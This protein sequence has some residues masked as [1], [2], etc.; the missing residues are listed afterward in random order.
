MDEGES[1][2]DDG[3][4][5]TVVKLLAEQNDLL[6][7]GKRADGVFYD[8]FTSIKHKEHS[9]EA[10]SMEYA[11]ELFTSFKGTRVMPEL[12]RYNSAMQFSKLNRDL[13]EFSRN[14][15]L[16][17]EAIFNFVFTKK[18]WHQIEKEIATLSRW[19][20][21]E[22]LK[23]GFDQKLGVI[24]KTAKPIAVQR[25]WK[26][27]KNAFYALFLQSQSQ[28]VHLVKSIEVNHE[29]DDQY[30]NVYKCRYSLENMFDIWGS[31]KEKSQMISVG[32]YAQI[33]NIRRR[34]DGGLE[35]R[36]S[37]P[38]SDYISPKP[39][40]V[41]FHLKGSTQ[42]LDLFYM[43][44]TMRN[45]ASHGFIDFD[46]DQAAVYEKMTDGQFPQAAFM[47]A[48]ENEIY[49]MATAPGL[50]RFLSQIKQSTPTDSTL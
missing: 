41:P 3:A 12:I 45:Y 33:Q 46:E 49:R 18:H 39:Y 2:S 38:A 9:W 37:R 20:K 15:S 32:E 34:F 27:S 19:C 11:T 29:P 4:L 23:L 21:V 16:Q 35:A 1:K 8:H 22:P 10:M 42:P 31:H 17:V 24:L 25:S 13:Y 14:A 7:Q 36:V 6:D 28:G 5:R 40:V 48:A 30:G 44:F 50:A 47:V 26:L 43:L